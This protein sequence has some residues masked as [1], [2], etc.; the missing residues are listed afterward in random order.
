MTK[1]KAHEDLALASARFWARVDRS[2]GDSA[3]WPWT[4]YKDPNGYGFLSFMARRE[5]A[6]RVAY[7]IGVGEIPSGLL[8]CHRCDNPPCCNP[9]HLFVG[10]IADN[11][12]DA[13]SKG[14]CRWGVLRGSDNRHAKLSD[15][16]VRSI[17]ALCAQGH[18]QI[19]VGRRFGV[20]QSC[21]SEIVRGKRWT[22]VVEQPVDPK[23][24]RP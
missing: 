23:G 2:G 10:T 1:R 14:R 13:L 9:A 7:T 3:C 24:G 20:R 5:G 21:V 19:S 22:H 4:R 6:H 16:D 12:R 11:G 17:R 15:S 18:T 8:V